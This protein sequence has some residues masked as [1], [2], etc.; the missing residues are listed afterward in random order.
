MAVG[1]GAVSTYL[2]MVGSE[3]AATKR[4]DAHHKVA[5]ASPVR[6]VGNCRTP[7][8][9]PAEVIFTCADGGV[10]A[11]H[12]HWQTWGGA[13]AVGSGMVLAHNCLPNCAASHN[14]DLY[15]VVLIASSARD[16]DDGGR[17]YTRLGYS[18]TAGSPY[19]AD[20]PGSQQPYVDLG[21]GPA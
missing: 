4:S 14:Y 13:L 11:E 20:A 21:C 7:A 6:L 15:P 10:V 1:V 3:G 8:V 17:H 18:W 2:V 19:P 9:R 16:C 12:V 5:S